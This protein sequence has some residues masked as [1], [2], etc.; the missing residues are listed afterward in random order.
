MSETLF[1]VLDVNVTITGVYAAV[2]II[3]L[4]LFAGF[5]LVGRKKKTGQPLFAGQVMNGIGF[6]FLPAL[7]VLKAF[8]EMSTGV[9]SAVFEP[10]PLIPWLSADGFFCPG[11]IETAAAAGCFFLL[12]LW[13]IIRKDELPDNGDLLMIS[14]CIWAAIRL[15]TEDFRRQPRELFHF[16]SC[17]AILACVILWSVRRARLTHGVTK[18]AADLLAVCACIAVNIL[19]A[20]HLL[21]MGSEIGD[22][23]AKAGSAFL[24]MLLT[25]MAGSDLRR[26]L[27]RKPD[28]ANAQKTMRVPTVQG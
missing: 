5:W 12:C 3:V 16:T 15:V 27:R 13:L 23:A 21:T 25:M 26:I 24:A 17:G 8:Q 19:T 22:F 4:I 6:G 28:S 18:M 2:S 7:A 20:T 10:L 11:R 14:I 1:E 9:G